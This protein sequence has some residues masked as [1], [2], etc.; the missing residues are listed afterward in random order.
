MFLTRATAL[1]V[2]L[3]AACLLATCGGPRGAEDADAVG[4]AG[5]DARRRDDAGRDASRRDT[6]PDARSDVGMD[7]AL[8]FDAGDEAV[9]WTPLRGA[10]VVCPAEMASHPEMLGAVDL[11]PCRVAPGGA[12]V[13]GCLMATIGDDPTL[14][15]DW[16]H[17]DGRFGYILLA[18]RNYGDA[19]IVTR[20]LRSDG[21]IVAAWREP[22]FRDHP[23]CYYGPFGTGAGRLAFG[24]NTCRFED[25]G[26]DEF[27]MFLTDLASPVDPGEPFFT[28]LAGAAHY[29]TCAN[30]PQEI[31]ISSTHMLVQDSPFGQ[32]RVYPLDGSAYEDFYPFDLA[33][34]PGGPNGGV[35][36][37]GDQYF[38]GA[39]GDYFSLVRGRPGIPDR[40]VMAIPGVDVRNFVTDGV[41]MLWYEAVNH[42]PEPGRYEHVELWTAPYDP[43]FD[44]RPAD[45]RSLEDM[46]STGT[47][48]LDLGDGLVAHGNYDLDTGRG[49]VEIMRISDGAHF[50]WDRPDTGDGVLRGVVLYVSEHEMMIDGGG[51]LFVVDPASATPVE[52]V[53]P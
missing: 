37:I 38:L 44:E 40:V 5:T 21:Q 11:V 32:T 6:G 1:A 33:E 39:L 8:G 13:E 15:M 22:P 52:A 35:D 24:L 28:R 26:A 9:G 29:V 49:W 16:G 43:T 31:R 46:T 14:Y 20:L 12:V 2:V 25:G 42:L 30:S 3:G 19:M 23:R 17:F 51:T 48:R 10:P 7:S 47:T 34:S 4:D 18:D 45:A 36:L 41:D 53:T 27:R 50:V